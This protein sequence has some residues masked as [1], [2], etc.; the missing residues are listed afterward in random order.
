MKYRPLQDRTGAVQVGEE[1]RRS[2]RLPWLRQV[3]IWV[4]EETGSGRR[5]RKLDAL[6]HDVSHGGFGLIFGQDLNPGTIVRARFDCLPNRPVVTGVIH[7]CV[8]L[9]GTHYRIGVQFTK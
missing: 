1:R 7:Y 8:H 6:I 2:A 4:A 9:G 5:I 3:P